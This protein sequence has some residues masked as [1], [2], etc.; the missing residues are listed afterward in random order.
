[1]SSRRTF[2][3]A[4]L[5]I[6]NIFAGSA[7]VQA[8]SWTLLSHQ[9]SVGLRM[10]LLL[11]DASVICQSGHDWYKL[12]PDLAGSY[13]NGTW[14][15]IASFPAGYEPYVYSSAVLADG[16]VVVIGGE[17]DASGNIVLSN[18]GAVYDPV[19]NTWT[20]LAPP[21]G[22]S[23]IGDAPATILA[24]G[25]FLIGSKLDTRIALL[26]PATLTW[27]VINPT[28]KEDSFNS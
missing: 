6:C 1:M 25:Q 28:G 24:N 21:S 10:C 18:Q 7:P 5:A 17:Y 13:V 4:V 2:F 8:Q 20:S 12:T 15:Q 3:P 23:Y 27:T 9:P 26:D 19:A 11:T 22:W 14:S 16:R